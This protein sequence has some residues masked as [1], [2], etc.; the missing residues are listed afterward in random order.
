MLFLPACSAV[1][2]LGD[3]VVIGSWRGLAMCHPHSLE[4]ETA[5]LDHW[6]WCLGRALKA[7][8]G[9]ESHRGSTGRAETPPGARQ[10]PLC[11]CLGL[12]AAFSPGPSHRPPG[13]LALGGAFASA[14][15]P[16]PC[17]PLYGHS[18]SL[19]PRWFSS[20]L[21]WP[22]SPFLSVAFLCSLLLSPLPFVPG[23]A[24]QARADGS[25]CEDPGHN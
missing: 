20:S 19:H 17:W 2:V 6:P 15:C 11:L 25:T 22:L 14:L 16:C 3:R 10:A 9:P 21:R 18:H 23:W 24:A 12:A 13:P 5:D 4:L 1:P 8:A 7:P